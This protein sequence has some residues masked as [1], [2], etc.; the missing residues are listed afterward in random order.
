[1]YKETENNDQGLM[2][3]FGQ[4]LNLVFYLLLI[5]AGLIAALIHYMP[6][7]SPQVPLQA[8][9]PD[10]NGNFTAEA[11]QDALKKS[12]S[13]DNYWNAPVVSELEGNPYKE[14]ILYGKDLIVHTSEY[15]G[16]HGKVLRSYTNG[17][18]CQNC[19]LEAGTKIFGNNYSSVNS[20]YPKYRAR[21]GSVE[22]VYKRINDCFER[23]LNGKSLDTNSREIQSIAAY[24]Q[25][26]GKDVPKGKKAT[27]AGLK[28][29]AVLDRAADAETGRILYSQK[30][31]S[32]HQSTG[33]GIMNAGQTA[34]VYPPLW[35]PHSYNK[36]AGLFRISNFAKFIKYNMPLGV[37]YTN[38]QLTDEEAWD[39]AAFVNSRPRADKNVKKD[40]PEI[41]EKPFDYPFGPYADNFDERQ[42]KYG[43]FKPIQEKAA[44]SQKKKNA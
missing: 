15:F 11:R 34:Y 7:Y 1:M 8:V 23:S 19:H 4:L 35:G 27:G 6:S 31:V 12:K 2:K 41:Q 39:I 21:S 22:N 28:D 38:T 29:V 32:C 5:I 18:N 14:V 25:W 30:C 17:M 10:A 33:E 36:G 13:T 26:L 9:Q 40:W 20:T 16:T 43:P 24:I 3:A 37:S 42:H 44:S